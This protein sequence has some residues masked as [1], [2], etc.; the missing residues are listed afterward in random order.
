MRGHTHAQFDRQIGPVRVVNAGSVGMP[1]E[2]APGAYWV[3]PGPTLE[4]RR[5]LY[6][7]EHAVTLFRASGHPLAE[8]FVETLQ[9]PPS[10]QEATAF[11]EER[12]L[13][14]Q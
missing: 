10:A 3:L 13:Q 12:A 9:N 2:A 5:T 14:E 7:R 4:L 1:Y 8:T 11:F 6:D